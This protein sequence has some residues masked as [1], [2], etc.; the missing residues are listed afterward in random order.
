MDILTINILEEYLQSFEG[1]I[2]FV[3]HDRYFVDKIAQKLYVF[4][5]SGEVVESHKSFSE[6]LEIE[7]ELCEY[8]AFSAELESQQ[9]PCEFKDSQEAQ[10]QAPKKTKAK[11]QREATTRDSAPRD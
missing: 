7:S 1:A 11:L 3:S 2:I 10:T 8:K 6:Y 9:T 5:G 4:K